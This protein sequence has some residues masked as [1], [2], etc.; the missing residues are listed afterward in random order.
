MNY[1]I[2]IYIEKVRH[3]KNLM[4]LIKTQ[5][6]IILYIHYLVS[7]RDYFESELYLWTTD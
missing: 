4:I 3:K 2:K 1:I 5:N 7:T 6:K